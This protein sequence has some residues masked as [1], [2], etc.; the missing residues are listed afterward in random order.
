[1]RNAVNPL[2]VHTGDARRV[3]GKPLEN[4]STARLPHERDETGDAQ[5]GKVREDIAQAA[6]DL[7]QGLVDTDCH[8]ARGIDQTAAGGAASACPAAPETRAKP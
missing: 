5:P 6:A 1:M 7:A 3:P 2:R 8:G 4:E